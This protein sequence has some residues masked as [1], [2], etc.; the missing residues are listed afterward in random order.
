MLVLAWCLT[1]VI[2]FTLEV[3]IGRTITPGHSRRKVM[4][5]S[6]N[7]VGVLCSPVVSAMQEAIGKRITI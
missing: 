2:L 4:E 3:E 5:I 7:K 6:I 1:S